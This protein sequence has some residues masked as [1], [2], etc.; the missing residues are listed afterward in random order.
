MIRAMRPIIV[1]ANWKMHTTPGRCRRARRRRSPPRTDVPGRHPGHLPAVRLPRRGPRRA[2]P[3]EPASR[4]VPRTSTTSSAGAYTGEISRA[5]A[6][7]PRR[8]GDRRPL[9]APPRRR[10]DRRAH[11][12][13]ARP[14]ASRP[15]CG[16]SCASASSSPSARPG[17][18]EA[19]VDGQLAGLPGR[20][21]R[22][23][24]RWPRPAW[25]SPTS[26]S[27]R[28]APGRTARGARRR[29]DGRGDPGAPLGRARAADAGP[30]T[31]RSSTAAAS[32]AANIGEFLAEPAIDGALVGGASLKPDEMAGIVA[33]AG[34]TA[35]PRAATRGRDRR[36]ADGASP[37]AAADRPR[38]PRRLRHRP[39]PGGRRDR[40]GPRCRPGAGC[41][42][43][44]PHATLRRVRGRR[45][46]AAGPDGQLRGGPPQPRRRPTGP[47]GPAADRRRDRRRLVLRAAGARRRRA[48]APRGRAAGSTSS[49]SSGRAASTPT[50]ATSSPSPSWP[51]GRASPRSASTRCST[52][53]TR[54]RGRRS[55]FVRGPRAR[56]SR[57]PIRTRGSRRSAAATSAMDRDQRWERVERGYDAIV[58]GVGEHAPSADRRDRGGLRPRR[59]RRVR[60][61]RRSSTAS[62]AASATATRSSTPTS[63][64]TGRA[65]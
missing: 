57:P 10:R 62:T 41:W 46:P 42:R 7:R 31:C 30:T 12:P 54:R 45:R 11:R 47:P 40:R 56:A 25:S 2:R 35:R 24:A 61:R 26:R 34:L 52:A 37:P 44:W 49:A 65:S 51:P 4:S 15:A 19:V 28:S 53:A 23:P 5:D 13:Q 50:T 48:D 20:P 55:A 63:G 21:R 33:R 3:A 17:A 16:R 36:R 59:E 9:G 38:R 60:A 29:G 27:G 6:R 1:A 58:H 18:A 64:P 14:G 8:L 22:M 43:D 32:R 39:R